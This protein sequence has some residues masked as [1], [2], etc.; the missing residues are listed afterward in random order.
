VPG[1]VRS[2]LLRYIFRRLAWTV[3]LLFLVLFLTFLAFYVLPSADPAQLRAGRQATP[4]LIAEIRT[5]FGLDRPFYEQFWIY[6]KGIVTDL[7][8]GY[9]YYK[10]IA[11]REEILSRVP[12][13]VS[14]ALGAFVVWMAIA[15]PIGI[16]A[17]L[18]PRSLSERLTT[19]LA[20]LSIS[21][22]T[23]F[24]GLVALFIF[25]EDIGWL[26]LAGAAGSYVPLSDDP[27]QWAKS[28]ILP[29]IVLGL[30][31][32]G[33]YSRMIAENLRDTMNEDFV[34]TARAKGLSERRVVVRHGL[35]A[36]LTPIVTLV[37]LDLGALLGGTVLVET[38]FNIPGVGRYAIDAIE[39][40]DLPAI[41]GTVLFG[42]I[43]IVLAVLV[44][45]VL[46]AVL[47]PRVRY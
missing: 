5:K 13:S 2:P 39:N 6:M 24:L 7:D 33:F 27:V 10:N 44:V 20:L 4:E 12:A 42:A 25:A 45:D 29:W 14:V 15:L 32:A 43:F 37:G 47:D 22:P 18:R 26:P 31:F 34:R 28:L 36:A 21:A 38:V 41:Q 19:G 23:Y 46:Y 11:V 9:S 16:N 30:G 40:A 3:V 1:A 8:L 17:A 35:R